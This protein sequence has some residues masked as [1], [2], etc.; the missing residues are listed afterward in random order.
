LT[1]ALSHRF[2]RF[3]AKNILFNTTV[4]KALLVW[5]HYIST[6]LTIISRPFDI[7]GKGG[8]R[9]LTSQRGPQKM[10]YII[11]STML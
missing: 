9:Q 1:V 7:T 10:E 3:S 4:L 8:R 6:K 5:F 11:F 2:M